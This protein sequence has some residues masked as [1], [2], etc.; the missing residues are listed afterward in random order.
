MSANH[1][2]LSAKI[3]NMTIA[4]LVTMASAYFAGIV[5]GF[6]FTNKS[7]DWTLTIWGGWHLIGGIISLAITLPIIGILEK[8]NVRKIKGA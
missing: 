2:K 6:F 3:Y 5:I 7:L 8:A 4:T 1:H